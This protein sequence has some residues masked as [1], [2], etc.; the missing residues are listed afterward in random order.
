MLFVRQ[1]IEGSKVVRESF[2][3]SESCFSPSSAYQMVQNNKVMKKFNEEG[4]VII[5]SYSGME[6]T[7]NFDIASSNLCGRYSG[8]MNS[9]LTITIIGK[10]ILNP[11]Y[12]KLFEDV[13]REQILCVLSE[14]EE[15][16][17][18]YDKSIFVFAHL[19][20]PHSPY[21][22]GPNGESVSPEKLEA[23]WEGLENDKEGYLNQLKFTNNKIKQIITRIL[24]E[25]EISPV[26]II[27]GDHGLKS[28]V[29]D[30]NNPTNKEFRERLSILNAYHIPNNDELLYQKIT[31]VN[32]FRIIINELFNEELVLLPD[33]SYWFYG[34][35]PYFR[36]ITSFLREN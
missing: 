1:S 35:S 2:A 14:L 30:W 17:S 21:V 24:D 18:R 7:R 36:E 28:K 5:N 4:Y 22:F 8:I 16:H 25:S 26:I 10:S 31:P 11:I 33:S 27:Q 3:G 34:E 6:P 13:K 20:L 23:R 32:S 19:L 15:V 29:E 9:E 12:V